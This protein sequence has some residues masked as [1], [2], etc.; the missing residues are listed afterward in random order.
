MLVL[1]PLHVSIYL[2]ALLKPWDSYSLESSTLFNP[3]HIICAAISLLFL[4]I[5]LPGGKVMSETTH[6]YG[7]LN[8][9]CCHGIWRCFQILN[10]YWSMMISYPFKYMMVYRITGR[11]FWASSLQ[12]LTARINLSNTPFE[13]E[14]PRHQYSK[15]TIQKTNP[16][17]QYWHVKTPL[18]NFQYFRALKITTW[19]RTHRICVQTAAQAQHR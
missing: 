13:R 4:D 9:D 11:F 2:M 14:T 3:L 16:N 10:Q 12:T 17:R 15:A 19:L 7:T 18:S 8:T 5:I 1:C 6:F